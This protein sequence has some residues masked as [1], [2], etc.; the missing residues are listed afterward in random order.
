VSCRPPQEWRNKNKCKAASRQACRTKRSRRWAPSHQDKCSRSAIDQP[1][2]PI[3][4]SDSTERLERT[5]QKKQREMRKTKKENQKREMC[6]SNDQQISQPNRKTREVASQV[7]FLLG[8]LGRGQH[9]NGP[10]QRSNSSSGIHNAFF[11]NLLSRC[12]PSDGLA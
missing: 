1:G 6:V 10:H 4:Q 3:C 9:S 5:S 8:A 12:R 2:W 11:L 7:C